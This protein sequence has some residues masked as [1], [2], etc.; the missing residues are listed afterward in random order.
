MEKNKL[1]IVEGPQ[2]T[3]KTTL[4]NYLRDNIASSN[5]HRLSGQR[6]KS[7]E[8]LHNSIKMFNSYF[9]LLKKMQRVPMNMIF[10]RMFMSEEVYSRLG[11]KE[12]DFY[13]EYL[14]YLK[15]LNLLNYDIYYL[16]LYLD[17]TNLFKQRLDRTSHHNY[18]AFSIESSIRQQEE[19]LEVAKEIAT[20]DNIKV[21]EIAMDDFDKS[22]NK[23]RKILKMK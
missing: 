16:S 21:N 4:T 12:Y 18:Q 13:E 14:N 2:G 1:I 11:Y 22:Y 20:Y 3:G 15:Q 19:Y 23:V 17:N 7:I 8:G 10:D 6:D 9:A 5:M